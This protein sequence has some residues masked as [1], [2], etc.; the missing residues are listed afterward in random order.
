MNAEVVGQQVRLLQDGFVYCSVIPA[1]CAKD[2]W[3]N[4]LGIQQACVVQQC[5]KLACWVQLLK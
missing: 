5:T 2:W 1:V 4:L 3:R